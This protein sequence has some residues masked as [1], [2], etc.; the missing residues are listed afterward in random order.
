MNT[1]PVIYQASFKNS[2]EDWLQISK[3]QYDNWKED[4]SIQA[5]R[6]LTIDG[7]DTRPRYDEVVRYTPIAQE[8]PY[9]DDWNKYIGAMT[10]KSTGDYILYDAFMWYMKIAVDQPVC[11]DSSNKLGEGKFFC[12]ICIRCRARQLVIADKEQRQ[13]TNKENLHKK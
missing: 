6:R 5:V 12:G 4:D 7:F 1:N 11:V 10:P 3:E 2:K 8:N 13:V 9:K